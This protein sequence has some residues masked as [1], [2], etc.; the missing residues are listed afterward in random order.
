MAVDVKNMKEDL[1]NKGFAILP[2]KLQNMEACLKTV[3][4][5]TKFLPL[6]GNRGPRK[7]RLMGRHES[8]AP[9]LEEGLRK[10]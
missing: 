1:E 6:Q 8:R 2:A 5:N 10:V 3:K 9:E 7:Q 4:D